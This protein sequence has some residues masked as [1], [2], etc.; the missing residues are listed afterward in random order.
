MEI[1]IEILREGYRVFE[2]KDVDKA[3]YFIDRYNSFIKNIKK[4]VN[5]TRYYDEIH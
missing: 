2:K 3:R 5:K 4:N 1:E